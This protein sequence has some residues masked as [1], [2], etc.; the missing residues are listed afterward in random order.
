M[1]PDGPEH[2]MPS[3]HSM[4]QGPRR[5]PP[6]CAVRGIW[7]VAKTRT[8]LFHRLGTVTCR[9]SVAQIYHR[10]LQSQ[11]AKSCYVPRAS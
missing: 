10:D 1:G 11:R 9:H 5:A 7:H 8:I 6:V 4:L 2:L 3:T